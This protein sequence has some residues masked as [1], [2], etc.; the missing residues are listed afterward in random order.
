MM[1]P[2]PVKPPQTFVNE[3]P[4]DEEEDGGEGVAKPEV[5]EEPVDEEEDGGEGVAEP[6]VEAMEKEEEEEE[7]EV[8]SQP[9]FMLPVR[10]KRRTG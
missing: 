9:V 7:E 4:V 8:L 1:A 2:P 3:E 10:L 5:K 6:E